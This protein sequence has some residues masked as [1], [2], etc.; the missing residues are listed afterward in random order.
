MCNEADKPINSGFVHYPEIV[1]VT[2][3]WNRTICYID[4]TV[5]LILFDLIFA[6]Y[7]RYRLALLHT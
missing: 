5:G 4:N 7:I 1:R 2:V 6:I 3:A